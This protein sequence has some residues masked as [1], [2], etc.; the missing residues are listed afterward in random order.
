[1]SISLDK[2]IIEVIEAQKQ[3]Y[4]SFYYGLILVSDN[5]DFSRIHLYTLIRDNKSQEHYLR[6]FKFVLADINL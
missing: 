3:L 4:L 1:M 2:P 6:D 5:G